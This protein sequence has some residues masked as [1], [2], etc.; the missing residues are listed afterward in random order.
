MMSSAA[1]HLVETTFNF[2]FKS[3]RPDQLTFGCC[4]LDGTGRGATC[5]ALLVLHLRIWLFHLGTVLVRVP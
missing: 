1:L 3:Y 2:I 5:G 4:E